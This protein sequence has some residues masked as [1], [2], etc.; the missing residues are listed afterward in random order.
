MVFW[1]S[2]G[3]LGGCCTAPYRSLPLPIC[4]CTSCS[5]SLFADSHP[6]CGVPLGIFMESKAVDTRGELTSG[7][8][9]LYSHILR[10]TG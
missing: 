2:H 4:A 8:A 1:P 6:A 7:G 9:Q 3:V 5:F 10:E